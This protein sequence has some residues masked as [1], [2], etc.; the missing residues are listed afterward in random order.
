MR[1]KD[2]NES[3]PQT[4]SAAQFLQYIHALASFFWLSIPK[5]FFFLKKNPRGFVWGEGVGEGGVRGGGLCIKPIDT[6]AEK[7]RKK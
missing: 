5:L 3:Q 4:V 2:R 7:K 6:L 1:C